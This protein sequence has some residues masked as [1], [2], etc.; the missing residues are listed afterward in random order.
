M[1]QPFKPEETV[2]VQVRTEIGSYLFYLSRI[3]LL[4]IKNTS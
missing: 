3:Q 2:Q 1:R 4:S